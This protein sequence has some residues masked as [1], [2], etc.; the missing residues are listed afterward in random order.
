MAR[1][2]KINYRISRAFRMGEPIKH[3]NTTVEVEGGIVTVRLHGHVIAERKINS[4]EV[5]FTL[6][7]YDT[8]TTRDRVNALIEESGAW[9][10]VRDGRTF[11]NGSIEKMEVF[12]NERYSVHSGAIA[13][14]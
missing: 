6:A 1:N 3:G 12:S 13:K 8:R 10:N 14:L 2:S 4:R 11:L 9:L 5:T 7:G